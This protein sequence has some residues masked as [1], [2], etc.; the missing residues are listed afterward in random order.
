[1]KKALTLVVLIVTPMVAFAQGT[2][3]FINN[4]NGLVRRWSP[5]DGSLTPVPV[6]GGQLELLVAPAGMPFTPLGIVTP[7]GFYPNFSTLAGFLAANPGWETI[8]ITGMNTPVA[9]RFN[10]GS[11]AL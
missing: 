8:A 2:V 3:G 6:G 7:E 5:V 10:G 1:M 11:V 9:G 4:S